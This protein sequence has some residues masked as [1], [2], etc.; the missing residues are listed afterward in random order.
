MVG[1]DQMSGVRVQ[2]SEAGGPTCSASGVRSS[3]AISSISSYSSSLAPK[4]ARS[5][6]AIMAWPLRLQCISNERMSGSCDATKAVSAMALTTSSKRI[7]VQIVCPCVM[8]GYRCCGP[9]QQS[10]STCRQPC[11]SCRR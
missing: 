4:C 5:A 9:S 8:I 6:S 2:G 10:S 3:E 7:T 11:S 1:E